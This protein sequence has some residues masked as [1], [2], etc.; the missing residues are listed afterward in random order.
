MFTPRLSLEITPL[1]FNWPDVSPPFTKSIALTSPA[2]EPWLLIWLFCPS[3]RTPVPSAVTDPERALLNC[4]FVPSFTVA[5]SAPV[6]DR[7]R[8]LLRAL[9]PPPALLPPPPMLRPPPFRP[10]CPASLL[11]P[12]CSKLDA[13]SLKKRLAFVKFD[14]K[15]SE[16]FI[17]SS[18][19]VNEMTS[20]LIAPKSG[21]IHPKSFE[22]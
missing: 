9:P 6:L 1:L 15:E 19:S 4:A 16:I 7:L 13:K 20:T 11:V 3:T 8:V 12:L 14:R 22:T 5:L 21:T 2:I 10:R 17:G 18:P